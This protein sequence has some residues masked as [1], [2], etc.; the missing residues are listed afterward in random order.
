MIRN[1]RAWLPDQAEPTDAFLIRAAAPESAAK[2]FVL[3]QHKITLLEPESV[4]EQL[5]AVI[6][7]KKRPQLVLVRE[8][9]STRHDP[10][11]IHVTAELEI[12]VWGYPAELDD[13]EES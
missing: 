4:L 13:E 5:P 3:T 7:L 1:Y 11:R 10:H 2:T 9:E 8:Q 6:A 12:A